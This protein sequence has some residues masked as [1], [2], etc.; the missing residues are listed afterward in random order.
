MGINIIILSFLRYFFLC[1]GEK[2]LQL[3]AKYKIR[4]T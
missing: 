2:V 4:Q 3:S 1:E